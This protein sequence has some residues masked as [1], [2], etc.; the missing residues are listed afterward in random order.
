MPDSC[1]GPVCGYI[2]LLSLWLKI[3]VLPLAPL[4]TPLV[5]TVAGIVAITSILVTK[6]IARKR[7]AIDLFLKTDM[8]KGMVDAHAAFEE[9]VIALK[10]HLKEGK[11][12]EEFC[13]DGK[14]YKDV[15]A[16]L[17][18]HELLA[19]GIKNKVF[20]E[21]VC[22]NY[23]SDALVRHTAETHELIEHEASAEGAEA[24]YLELR[25]LSIKWKV[26]TTKWQ[27]RQR[28]KARRG[29]LLRKATPAVLQNSS[30]P[31]QDTTANR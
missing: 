21:D 19:V 3:H 24:S 14:A 12:I 30:P 9:A 26:R 20:D 7:A 10:E 18:I 23:W 25:N 28:A 15:R 11:T 16:Y 1:L 27:E 17:N 8:D 5:A 31:S 13:K 6:S 2:H 29:G 22:Y 4:F